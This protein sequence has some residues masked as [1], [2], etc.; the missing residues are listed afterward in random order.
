MS[1]LELVIEH[2]QCN[3][4]RSCVNANPDD[5]ANEPLWSNKRGKDITL[6]LLAHGHDDLSKLAA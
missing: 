1:T 5:F 2:T 4:G 3:D 6:P